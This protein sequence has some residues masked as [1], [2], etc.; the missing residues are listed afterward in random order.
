MEFKSGKAEMGKCTVF[1]MTSKRDGQCAECIEEIFEGDRM[2]WD[3]DN[4]KAYCAD[5][6]EEIA[7]EDPKLKKI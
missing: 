7:G 5:C 3:T 6:G 4:K 2:V 1:W